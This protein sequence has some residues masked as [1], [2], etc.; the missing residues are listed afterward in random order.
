MSGSRP[1]K[2]KKH[3]ERFMMDMYY[4]R[5]F[6]RLIIVICLIKDWDISYKKLYVVRVGD[7]Y[8]SKHSWRKLTQILWIRFGYAYK[9]FLPQKR[10]QVLKKI[11]KGSRRSQKKRTRRERKRVLSSG[12][13]DLQKQAPVN[14]KKIERELNE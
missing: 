14:K 8:R 2:R 6:T 1:T 12:H 9:D 3:W 4:K 13:Q 11:L 10:R 7:N 5:F